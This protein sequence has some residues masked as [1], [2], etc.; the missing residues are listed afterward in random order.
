MSAERPRYEAHP[1]QEHLLESAVVDQVYKVRV[2][3]PISRA[4]GT[5]RFPVVY[6]TDGDDFFGGCATLSSGL[7]FSGETPRFILVGIGYADAGQA[8]MLRMRDLCT[9]AIRGRLNEDLERLIDSPYAG[10]LC[11]L[12]KITATTDAHAFLRFLRDELM[13]LVNASYPTIPDEATYFGYSAGGTFGLYALLSEPRTFKRY[14]LGS[15][16]TSCNGHNFAIELAE[17]FTDSAETIEAKVFI[18]VGELEEF[19]SSHLE[20]VSGYYAL[21]KYLLNAKPS[22]LELCL[23]VFPGESHGTAWTLAF[24]HGLRTLMGPAL[25][26]PYR[27]VRSRSVNR[28]IP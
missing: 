14:I 25:D 23:R 28:D 4:D 12:D 8:E 5:E 7:Q 2:L 3:R 20:L 22:G 18:S 27:P 21:A 10:G 15:P 24:S 9:H 13:P 11:N 1:V 16:A 26:V 17:S 19:R 6:V